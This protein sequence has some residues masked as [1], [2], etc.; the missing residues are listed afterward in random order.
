[1]DEGLCVADVDIQRQQV[2]LAALA[3]QHIR[4][5]HQLRGLEPWPLVHQLRKVCGLIHL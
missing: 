2:I 1:M 4:F 3:E 5:D